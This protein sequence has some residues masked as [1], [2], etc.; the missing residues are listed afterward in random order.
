[1]DFLVPS[2]LFLI[3]LAVLSY[4]GQKAVR[5]AERLA[6]SLGI[7]SIVVGAFI[8]G[9]GTD[10]PE[11]ANSVVS[12]MLGH[13]DINVGDSL[14]SCLLQ[15]T[16]VLGVAVLITENWSFR[17]RNIMVLGAGSLIALMSALLATSDGYITRLDAL[18]LILIFAAIFFVTHGSLSFKEY[19][20]G[21]RD[22]KAAIRAMGKTV[23]YFAGVFAGS[24]LIVTS[25]ISLST[26][27]GIP[28]YIISFFGAAVGTSIPELVINIIALRREKYGIAIGNIIGSNIVDP[29]LALGLGPLISPIAVSATLAINT[30]VYVFLASAI[31]LSII[32]FRRKI[33]RI[34]AVIA[35]LLYLLSYALLAV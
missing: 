11:I 23:L 22:T 6:V 30:G 5:N 13:G 19:T 14:G 9:V 28:E 21:K 24:Y 8:V 17:R 15:I 16:L 35:V 2:A 31:I 27:L 33:D 1:M 32:V 7:P 12:S 10:I 26:L 18:I 4:S 29:T 25:V 34:T 20:V 3:G